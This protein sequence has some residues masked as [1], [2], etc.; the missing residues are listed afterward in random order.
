MVIFTLFICLIQIQNT[1]ICTVYRKSAKK[2]RDIH[3]LLIFCAA[4][5][6]RNVHVNIQLD[7]PSCGLRREAKSFFF[8]TEFMPFKVEYNSHFDN[9]LVFN[10]NV[11][12]Q[13]IW[14]PYLLVIFSSLVASNGHYC[15]PLFTTTRQNKRQC[16]LTQR[17]WQKLRLYYNVAYF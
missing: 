13:L 2:Y 12:F 9:N 11:V 10:S 6:W 1:E 5:L 14:Q 15:P 3:F 16:F 4:L 17:N 7:S 8:F